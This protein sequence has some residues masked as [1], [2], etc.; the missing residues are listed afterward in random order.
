[1]STF[2]SFP[3]RGFGAVLMPT[4]GM[5]IDVVSIPYRAW[6]AID[7]VPCAA[8]L[9]YPIHSRNSMVKLRVVTHTDGDDVR[10]HPDV[11]KYSF[12][13]DSDGDMVFVIKDHDIVASA[14]DPFVSV[15][16]A[17]SIASDVTLPSISMDKVV[18]NVLSSS[19]SVSAIAIASTIARVLGGEVLPDTAPR[20]LKANAA[21]IAQ[22]MVADWRQAIAM[23]TTVRDNALERGATEDDC[24]RIF[25]GFMQPALNQMDG[26]IPVATA[27]IDHPELIPEVCG[28]KPDLVIGN[29][30]LLK[31]PSTRLAE[32]RGGTRRQR[33]SMDSLVTEAKKC[34]AEV[35]AGSSDPHAII[36]AAFYDLPVPKPNS[37]PSK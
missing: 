1:M 10:V 34:N 12:R 7:N 30:G 8:V 4:V 11:I 20:K 36:L 14:T 24:L 2:I 19:E 18:D 35:M 27:M 37:K 29:S 32:L 26:G 6:H 25:E 16:K 22:V 21:A 3:V 28:I 15:D 9:R 31:W 13:G 33:V 5:P 23:A 17:K